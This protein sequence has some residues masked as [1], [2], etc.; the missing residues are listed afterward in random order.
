MELQR[1][2]RASSSQWSL[3]TMAEDVTNQTGTPV[4]TFA[5]PKITDPD[6]SAL[7]GIAVIGL[8]QTSNGAW[9]FSTNNGANWT[10]LGSPSDTAARVLVPANKVRFVPN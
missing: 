1:R 9:Q 5:S 6:A 10:A 2:S 7:K 8:T 3:L 4:S